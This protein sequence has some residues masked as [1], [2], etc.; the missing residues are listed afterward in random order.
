MS[1]FV[2]TP[3]Q[4]DE[5]HYWQSTCLA[6]QQRLGQETQIL[7]DTVQHHEQRIL[8]NNDRI[9]VLKASELLVG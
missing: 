6:E 9:A 5:I 2:P 8:V 4:E 1:A 7:R 3:L